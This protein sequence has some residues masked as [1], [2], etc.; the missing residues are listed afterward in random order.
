MGIEDKNSN[1]TSITEFL[2][3]EFSNIQE[4]QILHF[5]GFL[6]LYLIAVM[7]NLLI[8]MAVSFDCHLHTPM[9]FF[10]M[11]LAV[12]DIG[13]ISVLI[14]KA[15]ANSLM[16]SRTISYSGCVAQVF[17]LFFFVGSD[18]ALLTVMAHDRYVAIC[19]P[20]QYETTM[21]KGACI[22]MVASAWISGVL[23][24]TLNTGSTFA[25]TFCSNVVNQFFC[26]IPQ[27]LKLSCSDLYFVEI[28]V[29]L[30][31]CGIVMGCFIFIIL[32][33]L[34]IFATV[35]KI[36]SVQGQK[37]ALSTCIPHLTVVFL[38]VFSGIFAYG[39]SATDISSDLDIV[40]AFFY[41]ILPPLLNPFI[42]TM[43][44]KEIKA[45]LLKLFTMV[46]FSKIISFRSVF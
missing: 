30:L 34:K 8:I 27:L 2:L 21:H 15:M 4:L 45:A 22:Q 3:L 40:F 33:Y 32:T 35:L 36:P 5:F 25:I 11:N 9:Y 42:Y 38:L 41:A 37:K 16:D 20:L 26:E 29:I 6:A 12:L 17:L 39:G 7:A 43:R 10:L 44:N 24:S 1:L 46:H 14:P 28:G 23:H 31:T 18:F 19:N 13:S